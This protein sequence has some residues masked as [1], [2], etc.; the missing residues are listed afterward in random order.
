MT[1]IANFFKKFNIA[2]IMSVVLLVVV[3]LGFLAGIAVG[4]QS[5]T[6]NN[7]L[8]ALD[9]G[10]NHYLSAIPGSQHQIV[11]IITFVIALTVIIAGIALAIASHFSTSLKTWK[12][13]DNGFATI[14]MLRLV[15]IITIVALV[16]VGFVIS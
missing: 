9:N 3:A 15:E 2:H 11:G 5:S 1:K 6:P 16:I 7:A 13:S 4:F 12:E 10:K 8:S 14:N